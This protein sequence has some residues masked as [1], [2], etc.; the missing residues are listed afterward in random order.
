[1]EWQLAL[2]LIIGT[3]LIMVALGM[4]V[5]FSFM[6]VNIIGVLL[7]WRGELGLHQ[8]I[9]SIGDSV[10]TFTLMP[11]AM[12]ILM[13]EVMLESGITPM[14]MNAIDNWL[15]RFPGRLS[16]LTVGFGTFFAVVSGSSMASA[17]VMGSTL[18]PE[19]EKRGYKK[20]MSLGPILGSGGLAMMIPPS[21]LAIVLGALGQVSIGKL[22]IAMFVPGIMMAIFYAT[23]IVVRCKLQPYIAPPYVVNGVSLSTKLMATVRYILPLGTIIFLVL[24]LIFLGIATPS[25]AAALGCFGSFI[26]VA[27]YGKLNYKTVRRLVGTATRLV[28]MILMIVAGAKA[29]SQILAFSG[30]SRGLVELFLNLPVSPIFV[31]IFMQLV[32]LLLGCF[33]GPIENMMITLPIFM[34]IISALGFDPV[35]FGVLVLLNMEMGTTTPPYGMTL[36][37]V[38]GV[39]PAGTTMKD[40][41][42][43]A[44]PFLGCDLLVMILLVTFPSIVLWL[45]GL[46]R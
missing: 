28:V 26:L 19:M 29:F 16:L 41:Y 17:A 33:M 11:L 18:L 30:A 23:Y 13:G 2:L 20:A 14:M 34:P 32:L 43:A 39:S 8:L 38:R 37:V 42:L 45:P 35:W 44:L 9:L 3:F 4:P 5:A 22:L 24:G 7:F 31:L 36:F 40:I 1:M 27:A 25:E 46:M 12:F 15:G 10:A 21:N 6:L